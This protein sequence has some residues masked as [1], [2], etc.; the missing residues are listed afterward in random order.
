MG[1]LL[2]ILVQEV[3][4]EKDVKASF[5]ACWEYGEGYYQL[6]GKVAEQEFIEIVESIRY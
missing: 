5:M 6:S 3:K 4:N 1:G 2:T